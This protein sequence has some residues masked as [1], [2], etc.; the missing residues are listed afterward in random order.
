MG[1]DS[2]LASCDAAYA[3]DA[4]LRALPHDHSCASDTPW[5]RHLS[6]RK[7]FQKDDMRRAV[8]R[9]QALKGYASPNDW[10]SNLTSYRSPTS[11][12]SLWFRIS[13]RCRVI[14][15]PTIGIRAGLRRTD[16]ASLCDSAVPRTS[17]EY[18]GTRTYEQRKVSPGFRS[19]SAGALERADRRKR[20]FRR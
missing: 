16:G 9:P 8:M 5:T 3:T 10:V 2:D 14:D 19:I 20:G 1:L 6:P 15:N 12:G 17:S 11:D 7:D 13:G 18:E 4:R